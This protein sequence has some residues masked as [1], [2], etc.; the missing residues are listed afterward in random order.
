VDES[1]ISEL[2]RLLSALNRAAEALARAAEDFPA[3]RR[4]TA[5]VKACLRMMEL[6]L[7]QAGAAVEDDQGRPD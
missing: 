6:N 1:R 4:N 2:T 7:G 3:L 5:R